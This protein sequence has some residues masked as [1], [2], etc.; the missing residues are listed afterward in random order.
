MSGAYKTVLVAGG[1]GFV[2]SHLCERLLAEDTRILCVDDLSTGRESNVTHLGRNPRFELI[3]HDVIVPLIK[4]VDEIY[5]LASPAS[6]RRYQQDPVRTA[7]TNV[8]GAIN[9]L[10]LAKAVNARILQ[11]STSEIY[12]DPEVHPQ[13]E[14]YWG[15]VNPVG[16]R[17]C[18][19]EGKRF[20]ETLFSDYRRQHGLRIRIARIFNTYG[21]RMR[22]D[23]GRVIS[24]FIVQAL[25]G[26]EIT[27][28]GDG[29]QTRSFCYID[30]TVEG[31][32][33]LMNSTGD[34]SDPV[35]IGNPAEITV[36]ALAR[37]IVNMT[38]A[39]SKIVH[40][41]LPRDDPRRRCPNIDKAIQLLRWEPK[42][43]LQEGLSRTI[44]S[45][46]QAICEGA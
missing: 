7:K 46:R 44:N 38:G 42:V 26:K 10:D 15:H 39:G 17:S 21:P 6:P 35:N 4:E 23:D 30:D 34:C 33:R 13:I 12:G 20:A 25:L 24:G 37:T 8:L 14:Q 31:L 43:D 18:Y 45:I 40:R 32:I 41:P 2:G 29:L 5:N 1:A 11:A 16:P 9:M 27:V 28:F 19:D 3:R 36:V 22:A